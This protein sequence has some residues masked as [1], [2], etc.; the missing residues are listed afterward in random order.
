MKTYR[1]V[2]RSS[3]SSVISGAFSCLII[4]LEKYQQNE[5]TDRF[6]LVSII[7]EFQNVTPKL[8]LVLNYSFV[9]CLTSKEITLGLL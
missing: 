6:P 2:C 5:L 7:L 9:N 3:K 8:F 1:S 4:I